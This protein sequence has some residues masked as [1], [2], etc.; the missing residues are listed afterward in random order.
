MKRLNGLESR[1]WLE[2]LR[3]K[4]RQVRLLSWQTAQKGK[5]RKSDNLQA[6]SEASFK[7][8]IEASKTQ[9]VMVDFWADWCG[10]CHMLTPTM[11]EIAKDHA[12]KLKV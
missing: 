2:H 8:V 11:E 10:P 12:G 7:D 4:H 5:R 9:P 1:E 3:T 6:V